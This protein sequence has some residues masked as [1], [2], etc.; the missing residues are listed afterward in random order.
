MK[1]HTPITI[2]EA[3]H[4]LEEARPRMATKDSESRKIFENILDYCQTNSKIS[5]LHSIENLTEGLKAL[6]LNDSE[7]V[8]VCNLLP[9]STD[10]M[11]T[12]IPSLERFDENVLTKVLHKINSA[13]EI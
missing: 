5:S 10:E 6:G 1:K 4:Y 11:R 3:L 9:Q 8:Q 2:S 12:I 13:Q 7:I